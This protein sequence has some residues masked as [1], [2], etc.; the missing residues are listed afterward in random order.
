MD[1]EL[2]MR[3]RMLSA[4]QGLVELIKYTAR[5]DDLA[6]ENA[7]ALVARIVDPNTEDR[8]VLNNLFPA[9]LGAQVFSRFI[10]RNTPG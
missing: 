1:S 8:F 6:P 7:E 4:F 2:D 10:D 5:Q 3:K 9:G